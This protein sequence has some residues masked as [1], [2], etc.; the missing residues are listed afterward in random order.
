[1]NIFNLTTLDNQPIELESILSTK[2][3]SLFLLYHQ[4]CLGCTGRAIPFAWEIA[5]ENRWLGVY[6]LHTNQGNHKFSKKELLSVFTNGISPLPIL[7]DN[8]HKLYDYYDAE[9]TPTWLFFDQKGNLLKNIFGSQANASNR[10]LYYLE[11]LN[12]N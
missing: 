12:P 10:L 5:K 2:H 3:Y 11:E 6:L 1:M 7:I 9:G 8:G 4:F